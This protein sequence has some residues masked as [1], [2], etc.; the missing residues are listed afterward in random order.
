MQKNRRLSRSRPGLW[1]RDREAVRAGPVRRALEIEH[2]KSR[3]FSARTTPAQRWPAPP[4]T[5]ANV[6][7]PGADIPHPR[8][9]V[10]SRFQ[11]GGSRCGLGRDGAEVLEQSV[12]QN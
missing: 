12:C 8:L 10:R 3:G 1:E 2:R 9:R 5:H 6:P 4:L 7:E 11:P